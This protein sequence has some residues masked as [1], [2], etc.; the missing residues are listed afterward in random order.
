[1]SAIEV[2]V[3]GHALQRYAVWFG[4]SLVAS[5]PEFYRVC[6]TKAQYD[7]EGPRIAR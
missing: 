6:C 1:A 2:N 4:G 7:E 3:I 5:G